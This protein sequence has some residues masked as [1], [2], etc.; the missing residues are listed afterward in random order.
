MKFIQKKKFKLQ[1]FFSNKVHF[2]TY[3]F[4]ERQKIKKKCCQVTKLIVVM[5]IELICIYISRPLKVYIND[6]KNI[7]AR[8]HDAASIF[9]SCASHSVFFF[10]FLPSSFRRIQVQRE[11]LHKTFSVYTVY[12]NRKKKYIQEDTLKGKDNVCASTYMI[13]VQSLE[14]YYIEALL[15]SDISITIHITL[16]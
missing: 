3:R 2:L 11:I 10:T 13:V 4:I 5:S 14:S 1:I 9:S 16:I 8:E 12:P 6:L 7:D 15:L